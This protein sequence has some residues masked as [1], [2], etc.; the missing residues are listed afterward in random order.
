MNGNITKED[1][2]YL[3]ELAIK[4]KEYSELDI[5]K[6][7]TVNWYSHNQL[8]S[9]KPLIV[10]EKDSFNDFLP[11]PKCSTDSGK[12]IENI[13]INEILNYELINDDKVIPPYFPVDMEINIKSFAKGYEH[14]YSKDSEGREIGYESKHIIKNLEEDLPGLL[15]SVYSF[16][17]EQTNARKECVE[18]VLGD[19]L[20]VVLKN[21][22][23]HWHVTPTAQIIELMGMEAM[24]FAM[25]DTPEEMLRLFSFIKDDIIG[26]VKWQE[27]EGLLT[28]NNGNDYAGAGSYGFTSEL[29][30]SSFQNEKHIT[31]KD[32]WVNMNSQES[33]GISPDMFGEFIFPSYRDLAEEFG[34]LYYGC[35]EPVH[36]VWEDYI[37]KLPNLRKVSIS[38]W[39][40]EKRMGE[41]LKGSEV[42]YSRKPSP[43]FIGIG[44]NLN[45][46]TFSKHILETLEAAKGNTLE[47]IFRDIYNLEGNIGKPG[48]AVEI[49]RELI[50]SNW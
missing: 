48:R 15:H 38:P 4:Y 6:E 25:F 20:P 30:G 31:T 21:T 9:E 8:K 44:K 32:L 27:E 5:M 23:L 46:E 7:R 14:T 24:M 11:E 2:L 36:D 42:I 39:C 13:L 47:F 18:E 16:D 37:S 26:Y 1:K 22:S 50:D 10:M 43:N 12:Y 34:M 45:E 35:C 41:Y 33:V 19:I 29:P 3:R 49:V 28:L 40:H 17:L